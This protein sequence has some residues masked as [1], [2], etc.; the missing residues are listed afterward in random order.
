[1][2]RRHYRR[3]K[4]KLKLRK[5]TIYSIFSFGLIATGLI[6]LLSFTK[7]GTAFISISDNLDK[8][9]GVMSFFAPF[10]LIFFGFLFLRIK[11]FL[12]K[13]N[14]SIGFLLFFLSLDAILKGGRTGEYLFGMLADILSGLGATIVYI[15][16]ILIGVIVFFIAYSSLV[17]GI[18]IDYGGIVDCG[19]RYY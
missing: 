4:F 7:N 12:S 13:P 15:A 11:I 3:G 18:F 8:N 10:I 5:G 19:S 17:D 9:F 14:I 16:G 6:L 1:M 2:R